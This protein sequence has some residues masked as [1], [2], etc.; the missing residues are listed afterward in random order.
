MSSTTLAQGFVGFARDATRPVNGVPDPELAVGHHEIVALSN[1]YVG[2]FTKSGALVASSPLTT[3]A[4]MAG[5][6]GTPL[7]KLVFDPEVLYDAVDIDSRYWLVAL[8]LPT[9]G[10]QLGPEFHLAIS[11]LNADPWSWFVYTIDATPDMPPGFGFPTDFW[12][13][14]SP[15]L[16]VDEA[17][18]YLNA[19]ARRRTDTT[20]DPPVPINNGQ[21]FNLTYMYAKSIAM[22]GGTL[23]APIKIVEP[24]TGP[25]DLRRMVYNSLAQNLSYDAGVPQYMVT[26]EFHESDV[27]DE[28]HLSYLDPTVPSKT[29]TTIALPAGAHYRFPVYVPQFNSTNTLTPVDCRFWTSVYRDGFLWAAQHVRPTGTERNVVRWFKFH[30][31]GWGPSCPGC[32]PALAG[33]GTI[34]AGPSMHAFYPSITVA[35]DGQAAITYTRAGSAEHSS[36]RMVR[37]DGSGAFAIETVIKTNVHSWQDNQAWGDYSGTEPDPAVP[38]KFWGHAQWIQVADPSPLFGDDQLWHTWIAPVGGP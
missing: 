29:T 26:P 17:W 22:A 36:M 35:N 32:V 24:F 13:L 16:A 4:G 6:F 8:S 31:N 7:G 19:N 2:V 30:M 11:Q 5:L 14:D 12:F 34:D 10:P 20:S 18:V 25:M 1:Q 3:W 38:G 9:S 37:T 23:P 27:L 21:H 15:N 28:V 33:W